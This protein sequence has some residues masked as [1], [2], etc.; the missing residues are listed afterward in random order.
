MKLMKAEK[1]KK[2]KT[3]TTKKTKKTK[4]KWEMIS[5]KKTDGVVENEAKAT[6]KSG[7]LWPAQGLD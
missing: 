4:K 3:T 7:A 5:K 1:V 6:T 2:K